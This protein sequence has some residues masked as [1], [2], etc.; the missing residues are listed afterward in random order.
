LEEIVLNNEWLKLLVV[1]DNRAVR[2]GLRTS[3]GLSI[4]AET[5]SVRILFDTG[6]D[7]MILEYNAKALGIDLSNINAVVISHGHADHTGGLVLVAEYRP[8]VRVYYPSHA[9]L[10]DYVV[11]LGLTP[12]PVS[13]TTKVTK[14]VYVMSE[15]RASFGLWE[16]GLVIRIGRKLVLICGCSHP[17]VDKMAER[18]LEDIGG[19]LYMVIGGLHMPSSKALD[20]L[21]ELG[22]QEIYPLHC[23]GYD[24]IRYLRRR[25]PERLRTGGC[26]LDILI[27]A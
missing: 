24:T 11:G 9:G 27:E 5:P 25:Y 12:C 22:V 10:E 19:D 7:P 1:V 23:S 3:W 21:I 14:E 4:Y 8:G 20:R 6:D 26:G 18:A 15:M 13:L 16:L 17:G 2:H